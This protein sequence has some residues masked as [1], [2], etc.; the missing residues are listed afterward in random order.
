MNLTFSYIVDTL[1]WFSQS[2]SQVSYYVKYMG[3]FN[4]PYIY[5]IRESAVFVLWYIFPCE[6]L[7]KIEYIWL[8][9]H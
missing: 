6:R 9:S 8:K 4:S 1:Q 2:V 7:W 5:L 3:Y